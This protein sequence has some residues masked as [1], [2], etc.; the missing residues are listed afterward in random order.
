MIGLYA[1]MK[2]ILAILSCSVV[3]TYAFFSP[4]LVEAQEFD[5]G[6]ATY[7][8]IK[9]QNVEDGSVVVT[10]PDGIYLARY[11][12]D[13]T[14]TGVVS[15]KSAIVL[16]FRRDGTYPLN[17]KGTLNVRVST[18]NGPIAAGDYLTSSAIPGVAMKATKSGTILGSA[19]AEYTTENTEEIGRIPVFIEI[20]YNEVGIKETEFAVSRQVAFWRVILGAV[21]AVMTTILCFYLFGKYTVKMLDSMA[22]NPLASKK[23][24]RTIFIQGFFLFLFVAT[25]YVV[26]YIL[27]RG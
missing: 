26:S 14:L 8:P 11:P 12:Y 5:L 2:F 4:N 19:I 15:I 20:R 23:I 18:V 27:L 9:D 10:S 22:R 6:F 21:L 1:N 25:G 24:K 16:G 17:T 13:N 3:M 7:V